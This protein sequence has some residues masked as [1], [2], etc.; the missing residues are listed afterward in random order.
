MEQ[1]YKHSG[2]LGLGPALV[3]AIGVASAL[4]LS[5]VYA[6]IT[7]YSPIAGWVSLFFVAGFG[8]AMAFTM[9][10][11]G[12]MAK[13]RNPGFMTLVG[14]FIGVVALYCSWAAF[15]SVLICR[16]LDEGEEGIGYLQML[17][18]P[19]DLWALCQAL[20][21]TGWYEIKGSTPSGIALWIMW[22]IEAAVIV[23]AT[24]FGALGSIS[25]EVFCESCNAWCDDR[26]IGLVL[27]LPTDEGLFNRVKEGDIGALESLELPLSG[28]PFLN[29]EVKQCESCNDMSS[30]QAK[31]VE[32]KV[33][34]K[35]N[36]TTESSDFSEVFVTD[37]A[38][39]QRLEGVLPA[40]I[41]AAEAAEEAAEEAAGEDAEDAED[42]A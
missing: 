29:I 38:G 5:L 33:D 42:S 1:V 36:P 31:L 20:N 17:M 6:Y 25:D 24:V 34:D 11:A 26:D 37:S 14:L 2:R 4:L 9:V 10:V 3:P 27:G 12:R 35:G 40:L 13:V 21:E 30:Y 22:G 15:E 23:G 7:V 18:R 16:S 19:G 8:I 32:H 41:A 39:M 28:M